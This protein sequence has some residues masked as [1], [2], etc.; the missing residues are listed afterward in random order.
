MLRTTHLMA[1]VAA[2]V[3]LVLLFASSLYAGLLG[4][5]ETIA[6]VRRLIVFPGLLLLA[7]A[8]AAS[9]LSGFA[10]ARARREPL[11][12]KARRMGCVAAIGLLVLAPC[13]LVLDRRAQAGAM[14]LGFQALQALEF[15][16]ALVSL[17]LMEANAR[18]G[19]RLTGRLPAEDAPHVR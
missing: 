7:P 4:S 6:A 13:A 2:T 8:L 11:T 18:A 9:A 1:G 14:D 3:L 12:A 16:A 10:L 15:A 19:M 17:M 5:R